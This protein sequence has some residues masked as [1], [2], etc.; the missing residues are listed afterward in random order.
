V[1]T[2]TFQHAGGRAGTGVLVGLPA[3]LIHHLLQLVF[4]AAARLIYRLR[5]RDH[6]ILHRLR[7]PE[8]I[9]YKLAVLAYKDMEA[10]HLTLVHSSASLI[11]LVDE[12]CVLLAPTVLLCH[13]SNCLQSAVDLFRHCPTLEQLA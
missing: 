6:I 12:R 2:A 4:N 9:Q 13:Q 8:R 3:Y 10:N 5:S 7:V 11:C 1:P